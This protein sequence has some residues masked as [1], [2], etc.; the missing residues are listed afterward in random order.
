MYHSCACSDGSVD[1][2]MHLE[3]KMTLFTQPILILLMVSAITLLAYKR[4][5]LASALGVVVL[6]LNWYWQV[7]PIR[8]FNCEEPT[9][10][11][12]RVVTYNI[13][14]QVDSTQYD[15]W[16]RD[17]LS[18][19]KRLHPDIL[20]LQE[21]HPGMESKL[22]SE[23]CTYYKYTT[24]K[25]NLCKYIKW[26]LYSRYQIINPKVYPS[27]VAIDT[28]GLTED[29][30][31]TVGRRKIRQ[32]Y[33]SADIQLPSGDTI[34]V[35]SCHLQSNG[36]STIRR[37]MKDSES[38]F[39]GIGRYCTAI[40][41]ADRLRL[42]E[43]QNLRQVLDSIGNNHPIIVA[44]DMNDFNQSESLTTIQGGNLSD[45]WWKGGN[46]LGFT[47]SGFGLHLRLDHILYNDKLRLQNVE[48]GKSELSDH[49]PL[50]ADFSTN[51]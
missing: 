36:Y 30:K 51:R 21:L 1:T 39:S 24:E 40:L 32:P 17:V 41:S 7:C 5:K 26:K 14:P 23:L 44:G 38:W 43:A 18:E 2:I 12:F 45:A 46:G 22:E 6:M 27:V 15:R 49:R 28:I 19:I 8:I 34:T 31:Y 33:C 25:T 29:Y 3:T 16:Q 35:F 48:V 37:S 11:T 47:Y 13:Y 50:I 10:N 9:D 4:W 42:W 20:C